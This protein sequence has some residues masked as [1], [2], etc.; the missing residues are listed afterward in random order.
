MAE[1]GWHEV[2]R[3]CVDDFIPLVRRGYHSLFNLSC[4]WSIV[5]YKRFEN[6]EPIQQILNIISDGNAT[7]V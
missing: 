2:E 6:R 4:F 3:I 5:I 1:G 7:S